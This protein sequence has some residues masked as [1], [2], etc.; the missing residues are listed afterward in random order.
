M[1]KRVNY[2]V[3][4]VIDGEKAFKKQVDLFAGGA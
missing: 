3:N 2:F 4:Q 1:K